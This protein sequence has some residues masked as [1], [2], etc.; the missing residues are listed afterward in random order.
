MRNLCIITGAGFLARD[1]GDS[2][3]KGGLRGYPQA[4]HDERVDAQIR[5][6]DEDGGQD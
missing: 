6:R 2:W 1:A 5:G 3:D 4:F